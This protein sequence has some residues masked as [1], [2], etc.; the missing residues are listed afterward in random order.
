M[1]GHDAYAACSTANLTRC[2]DSVC[3]INIS[4][5]PA[6]RCQ[7]CG[8]ASSGTPGTAMRSVSVGTSSKYTISYR[9]L[10]SA[11]TDPAAR[12]A[13]AITQCTSRVDECD[14][15]NASDAYDKLIEQSCRAA[16]ISA[17]MAALRNRAVTHSKSECQSTITACM[18]MD[19][20]C[21]IGYVNCGDDA[22]FNQFFATCGVDATGCDEHISDIRAT[23]ATDRASAIQGTAN[24]ISGI[25]ASYANA[26]EQKLAT[27]RANC[28]NN[29]G[30]DNCIQTVCAN[31]M[32]NKCDAEHPNEKTMA[33]S[34]C[35]FY[36]LAC[37]VLK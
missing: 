35:K 16:G 33:T 27:A 34:L 9:E 21:G 19:S 14:A 24:A 13:W 29:A 37:N 7:Y 6:A 32:V 23:L 22:S 4:S 31:N 11:P 12:Y 25:A 1:F 3:A 36:D 20:H 30:R 10:K 15:E 18:T 2:L 17:E 8:T 26:R 28:T 5:N